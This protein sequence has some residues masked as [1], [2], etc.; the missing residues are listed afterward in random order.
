MF[1]NFY[2]VYTQYKLAAETGGKEGRMPR[3]DKPS[4]KEQFEAIKR[5]TSFEDY[6]GKGMYLI[7]D[8]TNVT[9][10]GGNNGRVNI[11]D[12]STNDTIEPQSLRVCMIRNK[13]TN[14]VTYSKYDFIQYM[15]A[16]ITDEEFSELPS[17]I[18][19]FVS[20]YISA[21]KDSIEDFRSGSYE[22]EYISFEEFN[23]TYE[24]DIKKDIS[25][26]TQ[27]VISESQESINE[28]RSEVEQ[29]KEHQGLFLHS[30]HHIANVVE[31]AYII[32]K[33]DGKLDDKDFDLLIQAAK[34]HDSGREA[35]EW[36]SD[37]HSNPSSEHAGEQLA[38][39]N[40]YTP[41]QIAMIKVAIRYHEHNEKNKNE[42]DEEY[43][44]KTAEMDGVPEEKYETA[45]LMCQYLKDA[46]ALDRVRLGNLDKG[47]LRTNV[48]KSDALYQLAVER[49]RDFNM[50]EQL[51]QA[52]EVLKK[53]FENSP[54]ILEQIQQIEKDCKGN[55]FKI[56]K[57]IQNNEAITC[58]IKKD[59][60]E[61]MVD[62]V[63]STTD[64]IVV[65]PERLEQYKLLATER[66]LRGD[67]HTVGLRLADVIRLSEI[68]RRDDHEN[69]SIASDIEI[70]EDISVGMNDNKKVRFSN[71]ENT[72]TGYFKEN[73]IP[74]F[75]DTSIA[76]NKIGKLLGVK[77]A[78]TYACEY[79]GKKGIISQDVSEGFDQ[80]MMMRQVIK[81]SKLP[82]IDFSDSERARA[83]VYNPNGM[84]TST[85][86]ITEM[87]ELPLQALETIGVTKDDMQEITKDYVKMICFDYLTNQTD[88]NDGNYGVLVKDGKVSFAPLIDCDYILHDPT[89][90]DNDINFTNSVRCDR[91][92]LMSIVAKR[93][94]ELVQEFSNSVKTNRQEIFRAISESFSP[95]MQQKY[96]SILDNNISELQ[97]IVELTSSK[98]NID[99]AQTTEHFSKG[100]VDSIAKQKEVAMEDENSSEIMEEIERTYEQQKENQN[101]TL[102]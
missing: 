3:E 51:Q 53:Q 15:M 44:K 77:M 97:R 55:I 18:Q 83:T 36:L 7:F 9:N 69:V 62:R 6:L 68:S 24:E 8:G 79:E 48:A 32:G 5:S 4:E 82:K 101:P 13:D 74:V 94:P 59:C 89:D 42:F 95:E 73:I 12:A 90:I 64:G 96:G 102:E 27:K 30:N 92:I 34:Y 76:V 14:E 81:E 88:R 91:N 70:I 39:T 22:V 31:F 21:Y 72:H 86:K 61:K 33:V 66:F 58:E 67:T 17:N 78:E 80:F 65:T 60:I 99:N 85:E 25:E 37:N 45:R 57:T 87:F 47:Y 2:Y 16:N 63:A 20:F 1:A 98:E 11:F 93:Y 71:G 19:K 56:V 43:F 40:N 23:Q 54:N 26:Y 10:T 84:V 75:N 52:V 35:S 100:K 29:M 38:K 49:N 28:L 50:S 41:E 46:D